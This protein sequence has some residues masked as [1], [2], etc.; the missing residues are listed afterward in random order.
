MT[1][2]EVEVWLHDSLIGCVK[3]ETYPRSGLVLTLSVL[4][5]DGSVL[6]ALLSAAVLSLLDAGIELRSL[7]VPL[8]ICV[9]N[10]ALAFDPCRAEEETSDGSL[11]VLVM[12]SVEEGIRSSLVVNG[13]KGGLRLGEYLACVEGAERAKAAILAFWRIALEQKTTREHKTLWTL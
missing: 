7:P 2:R 6:S 5:N 3:K 10:D 9:T 12:D 11:V 13:A 1:D 8:T 4:Q